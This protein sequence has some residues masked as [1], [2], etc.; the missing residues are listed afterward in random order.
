MN[1]DPSKVAHLEEPTDH[2][3]HHARRDSDDAGPSGDQSPRGHGSLSRRPSTRGSLSSDDPT[4][5]S[6]VPKLRT[7]RSSRNLAQEGKEITP[8][9]T[10]PNGK[11][12]TKKTTQRSLTDPDESAKLNE[13]GITFPLTPSKTITLNTGELFNISSP[14]LQWIDVVRKSHRFILCFVFEN[15]KSLNEL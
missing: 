14:K 11:K 12:L 1:F 3:R 15:S 5:Q 13:K 8:R 7:G 2:D 9:E 6:I 4:A 10:S